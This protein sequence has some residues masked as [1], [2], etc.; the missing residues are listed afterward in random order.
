MKAN[1]KSGLFDQSISVVICGGGNA[2]HL[3]A[4][5]VCESTVG[6]K[7]Q[8]NDV[9]ILDLYKDEAKRWSSTITLQSQDGEIVKESKLNRVSDNPSEVIPMDAPCVVIL[10]VPS[11]AHEVYLRAIQPHLAEG[12]IIGAMPGYGSFDV[13]VRHVFESDNVKPISY[14][15][16]ATDEL[17]WA[18]RISSYGKSV[19]LLGTK[20]IVNVAVY[21]ETQETYVVGMLQ[22]MFGEVPK[23]HITNF[24][25]V[26]LSTYWHPI[27]TY[28][29]Y[30]KLPLGDQPI[31]FDSPPLFYESIDEYTANSICAVSKEILS[32]KE[33]LSSKYKS[34]ELSAV[35][36]VQDWMLNSYGSHIADKSSF[37]KMLNTNEAY[38]GL[39]HPTLVITSND[40]K[41][42]FVPDFHYRY[43]SE[44][45]PFGQVVCRGIAE[46][47]GVPTPKLDEVII[48]SQE[49]LGKQYL[50]CI[51]GT[52]CGTRDL[53]E[54]RCPQRYGYTNIDDFI[55][56]NGYNDQICYIKK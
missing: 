1:V 25:S 7:L 8:M 22:G 11:F 3:L 32:I 40:K 41:K 47:C 43:L 44:D 36:F 48:W 28:G 18:C 23:V 26:T 52:V 35:V 19:S 33:A 21:P 39:T 10:V 6:S 34:I 30:R 15:M 38:Q 31:E 55:L 2:A 53:M 20:N 12:S 49:R 4:G 13:L 24:M 16:F 14:C 50:T 27:I 42:V 5:L 45:V 46:L 56:A 17:P 29:F 9:S 51:N 54:T 37:Q